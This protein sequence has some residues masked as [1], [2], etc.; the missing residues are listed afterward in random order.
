MADQDMT[1]NAGV[2]FVISLVIS[3]VFAALKWN[4][5]IDWSWWWIVCPLWIPIGLGVVCGIIAGVVVAIAKLI[6]DNT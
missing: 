6:K 5:V 2:G 1:A 3:I 4:H